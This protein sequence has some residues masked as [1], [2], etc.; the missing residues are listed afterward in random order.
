MLENQT[1]STN[2]GNSGGS[3]NNTEKPIERPTETSD[4][5]YGNS[6]RKSVN[7]SEI[8]HLVKVGRP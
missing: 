6:G 8:E 3:S 2:T 7:P 4:P 5:G 1:E